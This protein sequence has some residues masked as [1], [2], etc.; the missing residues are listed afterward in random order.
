[1]AA[2]G[3]GGWAL[4]RMLNLNTVETVDVPDV[5]GYTEQQA[6]EQLEGNKLVVAVTKVNADEQTKGTVTAQ[7][8]AAGSPVSVNST[9]TITVNDGPKTATIPQG[10]VGQARKDAEAALKDLKFSNV[11]SK[12]AKSEDPGTKPGEVISISP[13]EGETVPLDTKI[14]IRYATGKS[15]VP[16]FDGLTRSAATRVANDA[17]FDDP[18]FVEQ[19]SSQ[20]AV[21]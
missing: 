4:Y 20:P 17:G 21:R 1:V 5:V 18:T 2:L 12:A 11:T 19:E 14:T 3:L 16:N 8:P 6:R 9:V 7:D 10:L 15:T 13:K